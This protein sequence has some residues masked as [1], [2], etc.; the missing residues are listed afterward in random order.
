MEYVHAFVIFERSQGSLGFIGM[1]ESN[2]IILEHL[3]RD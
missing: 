3:K 1:A 2:K